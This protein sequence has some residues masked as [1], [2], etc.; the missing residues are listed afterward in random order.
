MRVEWRTVSNALL[1]SRERTIT[2]A[3]EVSMFVTVCKSDII[4]AVGEPV[5]VQDSI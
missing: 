3:L 5:G 4:A 2:Y 1:K